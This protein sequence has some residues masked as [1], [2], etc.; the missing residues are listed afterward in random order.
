MPD[1]LRRRGIVVRDGENRLRISAIDQWGEPLGQGIPRVLAE[2]LA[3]LSPGRETVPFPWWS[4]A[5]PDLQVSIVITRLDVRPGSE[6]EL[7]ASW[8]ITRPADGGPL[9]SGT[10]WLRE[11]LE[12][13][14][15]ADVVAGLS[16]LL[17]RWSRDLLSALQSAAP[18]PATAAGDVPAS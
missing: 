8:L 14:E 9:S 11:P 16:R 6:I 7:L 15:T 2:N 5:P 18:E 10:T 4:P 3:V 17:E 13:R 12:G 1:H